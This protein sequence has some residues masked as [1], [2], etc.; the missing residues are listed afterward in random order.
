MAQPLQFTPF[1]ELTTERLVLRRLTVDDDRQIFAL[2]TDDG[3]NKYLDRLK[4]RTLDEARRFIGKMNDGIDSNQLLYWGISSR[5]SNTLI[6]TACFW[7]FSQEEGK[8]ETGYE[9]LPAWQGRG[10]MFEAMSRV[11]KYGFEGIGLR[12]IDA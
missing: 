9:L 4:A 1:P 10:L 3:V 12:R 7:N 6:G 5:D 8:V 2:R 11:V